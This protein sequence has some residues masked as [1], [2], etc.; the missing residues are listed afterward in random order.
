MAVICNLLH[1]HLLFPVLV[2][3]IPSPSTKLAIFPALCT[4]GGLCQGELNTTT[5]KG[6]QLH[7][8]GATLTSIITIDLWEQGKAFYPRKPIAAY[9]YLGAV[10]VHNGRYIYVCRSCP[11]SLSLS[12]F[13][14]L[15]ISMHLHQKCSCQNA[16]Q[17]NF[18]RKIIKHRYCDEVK[19]VVPVEQD[20]ERPEFTK[21]N[22][23]NWS[24][25]FMAATLL[26]ITA[27]FQHLKSLLNENLYNF[28]EVL[29]QYIC[30]QTWRK[31]LS[32][33]KCSLPTLLL[34][35]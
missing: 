6:L 34:D 3:T 21:A 11:L 27:T 7:S 32:Y 17:F 35:I 25:G 22:G 23:L 15:S 1:I 20:V 5:A 29:S 12:S 26:L 2:I 13:I 8:R 19:N 4:S 30:I 14:F 31:F 9:L 28:S 10:L 18:I 33:P 24:N 16:S